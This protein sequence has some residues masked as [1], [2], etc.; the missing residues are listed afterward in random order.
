MNVE[1]PISANV[2]F[3]SELIQKCCVALK[4]FGLR[5]PDAVVWAV[6]LA[7]Q[8]YLKDA[9]GDKSNHPHR[10]ITRSSLRSTDPSI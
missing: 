1:K 2:T 9:L 5:D 7:C 4:P 6:L 8:G 10:E 3:P